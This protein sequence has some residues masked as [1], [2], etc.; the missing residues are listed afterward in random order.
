MDYSPSGSSV[1]GVLQARVLECVAISFSK[2]V[3]STVQFSRS[4]VSDSLRPHELQHARPS[5]PSP[6]PGVDSNPCPLSWWCH[7]AISSSLVPSS[8]CPQSFTASESFPMNQLFALCGQIIGA[9]ASASVFPVYSGLISL[10][11]DWFDLFAVQGTLKS[12][13]QQHSSKESILQCLAFFILQLLHPYKT[14]GKKTIALS[15]W[16]FVSKV[17]SLLF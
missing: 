17:T 6:T 14:T 12:L 16:T 11:I 7:P 13:L 9:S 5:C 3:F 10:R 8:S 2:K 4:V 15:R 1:H